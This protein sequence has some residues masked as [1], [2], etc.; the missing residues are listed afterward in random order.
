MAKKLKCG[1]YWKHFNR[2]FRRKKKNKRLRK[3]DG[4]RK[5][6]SRIQ[7]QLRERGNVKNF[8]TNVRT[9]PCQLFTKLFVHTLTVFTPFAWVWLAL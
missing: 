5:K 6:I 3:R 4:G 2:I 1:I 8:Y 9:Y 7:E